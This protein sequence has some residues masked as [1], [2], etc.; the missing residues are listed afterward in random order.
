MRCRCKACKES[1]G[2]NVIAS[3]CKCTEQLSPGL[4]L[5][6]MQPTDFPPSKRKGH[7]WYVYLREWILLSTAWICA[8]PLALSTYAH[9][10]KPPAPPRLWLSQGRSLERQHDSHVGS[11]TG[12]Q[13]SN[14]RP[15]YA[16]AHLGVFFQNRTLQ[17]GGFPVG[18]PLK[19]P[20]KGQHQQKNIHLTNHLIAVGG[21][22][23]FKAM[24]AGNRAVLCC[25]GQPFCHICPAFNI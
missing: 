20:N 19:P 14:G 13:L 17:N 15:D 11:F 22:D 5:P 21:L 18:L 7:A 3:E 2:A 16:K 12:R 24:P 23:S 25:K 10:A 1:N 6:G 8:T 4:N 9:N